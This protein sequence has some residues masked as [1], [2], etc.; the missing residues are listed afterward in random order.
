LEFLRHGGGIIRSNPGEAATPAV[1][2]LLLVL[3]DRTAAWQTA[4]L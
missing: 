1:S 3:A 2:R 4:E